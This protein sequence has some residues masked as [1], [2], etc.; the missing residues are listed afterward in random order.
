VLIGIK[1]ARLV[2]RALYFVFEVVVVHHVRKSDHHQIKGVQIQK[3]AVGVVAFIVG[4]DW[5]FASREEGEGL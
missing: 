1:L 2:G 3:D 5:R 4:M